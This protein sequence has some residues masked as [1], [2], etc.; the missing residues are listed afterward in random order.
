M[1]FTLILALAAAT[2]S[3]QAPDQTQRT[4]ASA[5]DVTSMIA[6]ARNERT[7]DQANFIQPLLRAAGYTANLE[8]RVKGVDTTPNVH[9]REAELVYV[10]DGG[11]TFTIGGK[12]RG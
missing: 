3:A 4:F 8:Y 10:I 2:A 12:L 1:R 5:T 6:K 9:E 7:P 11:G